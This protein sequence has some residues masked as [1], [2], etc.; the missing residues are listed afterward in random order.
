MSHVFWKIMVKNSRRAPA[1]LNT[2]VAKITN[3]LINFTK[4]VT[5]IAFPHSIN[6]PILSHVNNNSD[7]RVI[8]HSKL[9][10]NPHINNIINRENT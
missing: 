5:P 10:F 1:Y 3:N 9:T 4:T 2:P 6:N 7:F 8:F